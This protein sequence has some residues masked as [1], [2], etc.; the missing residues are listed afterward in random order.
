ML[1]GKKFILWV[2][3]PVLFLGGILFYESVEYKRIQ[4]V[5]FSRNNAFDKY[6][7]TKIWVMDDIGAYLKIN[8]DKSY[9]EVKNNFHSV[10]VVKAALFGDAYVDTKFFGATSVSFVDA[11]YEIEGDNPSVMDF[12]I[13]ANVKTNVS[14]YEVKF[15]VTVEGDKISYIRAY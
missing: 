7:A 13:L 10:D 15:L 2:L 11:Q 4:E 5:H 9:N 14:L 6:E 3:I 12:L 8:S 1:K